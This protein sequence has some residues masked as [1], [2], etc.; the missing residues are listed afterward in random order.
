[1][2]ISQFSLRNTNC[3]ASALPPKALDGGLRVHIPSK[4]LTS[5]GLKTGDYCLLDQP[6]GTPKAVGVAWLA[7][8]PGQ[9]TKCMAFIEEP[10]KELYGLKLGDK[11]TIS[12]LD[13]QQLKPAQKIY[14][15]EVDAG[16]SAV[17]KNEIE[18]F[19]KVALCTW[20][21]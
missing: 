19:A 6:D 18:F 3:K 12:K 11:V 5:L 10:M 17:P 21:T 4:H 7:K 13:L 9:S 15:K 20:F 16:S 14:V 8:D 2:D 1:M